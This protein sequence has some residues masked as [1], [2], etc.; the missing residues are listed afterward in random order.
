MNLLSPN[1]FPLKFSILA[2]KRIFPIKGLSLLFFL[3]EDHQ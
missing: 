3:F 1:F 2:D